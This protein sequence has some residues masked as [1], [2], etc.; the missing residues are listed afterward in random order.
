M[1]PQGEVFYGLKEVKI[2][3]VEYKGDGRFAIRGEIPPMY[4]GETDQF[5]SEIVDVRESVATNI[6][7][8]SFLITPT[9]EE[10][11]KYYGRKNFID[12]MA[13]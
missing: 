4:D 8:N 7:Q 11:R 5:G 6:E 10:G 3:S 2:M 12:V 9:T 1:P 13:V